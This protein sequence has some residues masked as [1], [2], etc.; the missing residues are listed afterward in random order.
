MRDEYDGG[1]GGTSPAALLAEM[2]VD[3]AGVDGAAVAV[4]AGAPLVR[5]LIHS[6][7]PAATRIDE[8][9]FTIGEGP[10]LEAFRTREPHLVPDLLDP[11]ASARWPAFASAVLEELEVRSVFAFPLAAGESTI[12]SLELY[13]T[14]PGELTVVQHTTAATIAAMIGP[15]L[16]AEVAA[17]SP[18][19]EE[20]GLEHAAAEEFSRAEVHTAIGMLAARLRIPIDDAAVRLRGHA[21][22]ESQPISSVARDLMRR[23]LDPRILDD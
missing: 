20:A 23:V 18:A 22:A 8:L 6:T 10:C 11:T 13:R 3:A 21:Y 1:R 14:A 12:G 5:E 19:D 2:A 17:T 9:Q 16:V 7:D 4:I 15:A